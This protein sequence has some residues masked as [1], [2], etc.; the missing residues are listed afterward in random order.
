[1]SAAIGE[2]ERRNVLLGAAQCGSDLRL[3]SALGGI[4]SLHYGPGDVRFA[5]APRGLVRC[6]RSRALLVARRS[7]AH[8]WRGR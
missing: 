1:M 3:Y 5:H 2:V 6:T 4:R 8:P 7:G